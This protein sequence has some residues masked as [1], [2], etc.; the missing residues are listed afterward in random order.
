[1]GYIPCP[2]NFMN[3]S[4]NAEQVQNYVC[5]NLQ[6]N[7]NDLTTSLKQAMNNVNAQRALAGIRSTSVNFNDLDIRWKKI[8]EDNENVMENAERFPGLASLYAT[9]PEIF[10]TRRPGATTVKSILLHMEH[11]AYV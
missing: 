1:M 3:D 10:Y 8:G 11:L 7:W 2:V 5:I 9:N 6:A 4:H